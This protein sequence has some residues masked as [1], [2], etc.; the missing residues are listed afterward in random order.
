VEPSGSITEDP[1]KSQGERER[2][3]GAPDLGAAAACFL[4]DD[5][6]SS[7]LP[8]PNRT[9]LL[10]CVG[11]KGRPG[12]LFASAGL[13]RAVWLGI[14]RRSSMAAADPHAPWAASSAARRPVRIH[15][16]SSSSPPLGVSLVQCFGWTPWHWFV[17]RR[18]SCRRGGD[19]VRRRRCPSERRMKI[20]P[21]PLDRASTVAI[22]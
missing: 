4:N 19:P 6:T 1:E 2:E 20:H 10:D 21:W 12:L 8:S 9:S 14:A 16:L 22:R 7:A 5:Q 11:G 17:L 18:Q 15:P 13:R 3:Q